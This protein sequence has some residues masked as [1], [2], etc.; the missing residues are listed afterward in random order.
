VEGI[1]VIDISKSVYQQEAITIR[2][3]L[4]WTIHDYLTYGFCSGLGTKA[5]K[6]CNAPHVVI[7]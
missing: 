7:G 2:V 6:A 4:A 1:N 3:I 5:F